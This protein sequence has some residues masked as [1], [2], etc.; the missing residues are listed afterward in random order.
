MQTSAK[1]REENNLS[2]PLMGLLACL[3]SAALTS[4]SCLN[5]SLEL[6]HI[7]TIADV[8][9]RD[10]NVETFSH[11]KNWHLAHCSFPCVKGQDSHEAQ[12]SHL[13]EVNHSPY[14]CSL[15][16]IVQVRKT[17][18]ITVRDIQLVSAS[19]TLSKR[20]ACSIPDFCGLVDVMFGI[21][22]RG[23]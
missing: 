17:R 3:L 15:F 10:E 4:P 2:A 16:I 9:P 11:P 8:H 20:N 7:K 22:W 19:Y 1:K 6:A 12:F 14:P 18:A 21:S 13:P 5:S 23:A